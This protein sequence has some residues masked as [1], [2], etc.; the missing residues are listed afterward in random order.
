MNV[1]HFLICFTK[2]NFN[3]QINPQNKFICLVEHWLV[4]ENTSANFFLLNQS[5][6]LHF[7]LPLRWLGPTPGTQTL[8]MC[9]LV[10]LDPWQSL[11]FLG[12]SRVYSL[13]LALCIASRFHSNLLEQLCLQVERGGRL[14][15]VPKSPWERLRCTQA[16]WIILVVTKCSFK[17]TKGIC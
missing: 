14:K 17:E 7:S 16:S 4:K 8:W 1:K 12:S 13:G 10:P 11:L 9:R 6:Y 3:L 15:I 5:I 2:I